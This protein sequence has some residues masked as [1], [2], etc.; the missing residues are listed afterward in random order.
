MPKTHFSPPV[1]EPRSRGFTLLEMLAVLTVLVILTALIFP[2]LQSA[3]ESSRRAKCLSLHRQMAA[4]AN[5][6]AADLGC[7]PTS[8]YAADRPPSN[9]PYWPQFLTDYM[10]VE[11]TAAT[12]DR[13]YRCPKPGA[14]GRPEFHVYNMWM[15]FRDDDTQPANKPYI[16]ISPAAV[17]EPGKTSI[18]TCG[19]NR[20]PELQSQRHYY[21]RTGRGGGTASVNRT[22]FSGGANWAFVDGHAEWLSEEDVAARSGTNGQAAPFIKPF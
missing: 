11:N 2:T 14:D 3:M 17:P 4:A 7:F 16:R 20:Q 18:F 10:G 12:R 5:L 21:Y 9:R 22:K 8:I 15:G 6:H 19:F 13:I 1:P